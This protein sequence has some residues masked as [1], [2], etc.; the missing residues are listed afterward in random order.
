[1]NCIKFIRNLIKIINTKRHPPEIVD[2]VHESKIVNTNTED[3]LES[4]CIMVNE[5]S[6]E[7]QIITP[8]SKNIKPLESLKYTNTCAPRSIYKAITYLYDDFYM[9][10][11][12]DD[13]IFFENYS[14]HHCPLEGWFQH[15]VRCN[16]ITGRLYTYG[17]FNKKLMRIRMCDKCC[18]NFDEFRN[19]AANIEL[20]SLIRKGAKIYINK[21]ILLYK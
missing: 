4:T 18:N 9:A 11:F 1:M 14:N 16:T 3:V 15:C 6:E 8:N 2:E 13:L 19:T 12:D 10:D 7:L 21:N 5:I 17:Y 20:D